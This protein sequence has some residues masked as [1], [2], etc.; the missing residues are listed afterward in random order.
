MG[1]T[2]SCELPIVECWKLNSGS[3]RRAASTFDCK[4]I[5]PDLYQ[6]FKYK[7]LKTEKYQACVTSVIT[8]GFEM[9]FKTSVVCVVCVYKYMYVHAHIYTY[10]YMARLFK[11]NELKN[12]KYAYVCRFYIKKFFKKKQNLKFQGN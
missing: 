7:A 4:T 12:K 10:I 11:K 8:V 2:D 6:S 9:K 1:V 3:C 5:L